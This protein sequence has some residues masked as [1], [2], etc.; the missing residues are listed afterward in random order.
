VLT[1]NYDRLLERALV[2][3]G[4]ADADIRSKLPLDGGGK[5]PFEVVHLHGV[6]EDASLGADRLVLAED[7]YLTESEGSRARQSLV[8]EALRRP[9]LFVGTSLSDPNILRYLYAARTAS[10]RSGCRAPTA[11]GSYAHQVDRQLP[12]TTLSGTSWKLC[13]KRRRATRRDKRRCPKRRL[14]QRGFRVPG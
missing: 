10:T 9:S 3:V 11:C 14:L 2:E 12:V 13:A 6:I 4:I 1:T 8:L 7:E 5:T